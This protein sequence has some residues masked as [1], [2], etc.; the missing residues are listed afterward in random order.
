MSKILSSEEKIWKRKDLQIMYP[1]N[2]LYPM[3]S[4]NSQSSKRQ[5]RLKLKM[6]KRLNRHFTKEGIKMINKHIKWHSALLSIREIQ[7]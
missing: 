2:D 1:I 4:K 5:Q 6:S 7:I 3:Y